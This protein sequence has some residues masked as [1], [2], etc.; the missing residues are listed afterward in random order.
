MKIVAL[1]DIKKKDGELHY[2]KVYTGT[3]V[4]QTPIETIQCTVE[5]TIEHTPL[6]SVE[7]RVALKEP[8]NY[9]LLPLLRDLK[10]YATD[11]YQKGYLH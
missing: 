5:I 8:V 1:K 6:G 4:L 2:R 10:T 3:A 11:L 9:P 7:T